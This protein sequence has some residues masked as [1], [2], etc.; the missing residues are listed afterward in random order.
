MSADS[1]PDPGQRRQLTTSARDLDDLAERLTRWLAARLD[2]DGPPKITNLTR[3]QAGGMSSS[4]VLFDAEWQVDGRGGGGS[5]V[6]RMAPEAGSFPVFETYDLETQ[7]AVMAG[8][9]EHTD[10]PVPPLCWLETD[11]SVLGT[12]FFV[13]RRVDGR[14]PEDNPPYVFVGW[15]FDSTADERLRLTRNTV[16]VIARIHALPDPVAKFP[17]LDGEGSALRRHVDAQ[18]AWYRWALADDG[19]RIPLLERAFEWLEE[20]WPADPGPDVLSW[21]DARP[22]NVIYQG[23]EPA[24]V[25][26]WEMAA[27]GPR[28]LDIAWIIFIHRFFQDIATRFDQPGLPDYL[29]RG[30]VVDHYRQLTGYTVRDLDW[31]LVYAA[32]RHG[33]V[34]ARVKRRMIHFGEDTDTADRDDYVMHRPS[35]E[36]LLAGNYE[37]D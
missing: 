23:F 24:A 9:A 20:H 14:I 27:L 33:I 10:V 18:K 34:M 16:D 36:A 8:V 12:P 21:G 1:E 30:D 15:L 3:P 37:W 29:R 17:M 7:Y 22:G 35:L 25:L 11:E 32:L 6:A 2:S 26:D 5:Y 28:E 13:M 19:Y 4:S 31:Y